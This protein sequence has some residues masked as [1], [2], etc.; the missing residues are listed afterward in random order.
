MRVW[1]GENSAVDVNY[2]TSEAAARENEGKE[3]PPELAELF[4]KY[5]DVLAKAEFLD[6][7]DPWL[8]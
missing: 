8:Y 1:T 4:A 6:L 3:P 7:R 2:F 5:G